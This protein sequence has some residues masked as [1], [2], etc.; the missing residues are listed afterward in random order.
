VGG[1]WICGDDVL[2]LV[3]AL[4]VHVARVLADDDA[5]AVLG[6]GLEI[7]LLDDPSESGEENADQPHSSH[8][9]S[10]LACCLVLERWER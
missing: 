8:G 6:F 2:V 3:P 7:C 4:T 5:D 10:S 1:F 9:V